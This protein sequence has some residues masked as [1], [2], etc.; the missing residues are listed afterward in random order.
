MKGAPRFRVLVESS[1]KQGLARLVAAVGGGEWVARFRRN[2]ARQI[3]AVHL[4]NASRL[5]NK[6]VRV[7]LDSRNHAEHHAVSTQMAD[8]GAGVD[9]GQ[10][11]YGIALH[12]LVGD[13][14]GA[15]V[16][17]D[18]R[19]L[20]D[21]QALDKGPGR[22]VVRLVSA[23]VADLRVGEHHNLAGIGGV[24]EDFL[25]SGQRSIKNNFTPAFAR[26]AIAVTAKDAPVFERQNCLHRLS[27][28]LNST[29]SHQSAL[30]SFISTSIKTES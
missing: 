27:E 13:L 25:V 3:G 12:V 9:L 28:G 5:L 6:D 22:L 26:S 8:Q 21:A 19:K 29:D 23:V 10:H 15:P 30:S 11:G 17:T 20:A 18:G 4:A 16:G 14:R 1:G 2:H 24:G 7:A